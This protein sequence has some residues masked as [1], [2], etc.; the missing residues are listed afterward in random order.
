MLLPPIHLQCQGH[1]APIGVGSID[2][3][4]SFS[5]QYPATGLPSDFR[6]S[7]W[8]IS[9]FTRDNLASVWDSGKNHSPRSYAISVADLPL[10][11]RTSYRWHL[12]I[13]DQNDQELPPAEAGFETGLLTPADWQAQWVTGFKMMRKEFTLPMPPD[14]AR[15]YVSAIGYYEVAINGQRVGDHL[16]DPS[17]TDFRRR[18]EF[19]THDVTPLLSAGVNVLTL[20]LGGGFPA[21]VPM[22]E[23]APSGLVQLEVR[24]ADTQ[25]QTLATD[26]TWRGTN[27]GPIIE[28]SLYD[29]ETFDAR[30]EIPGWEL[31][32]YEGPSQPVQLREPPTGVLV[33]QTHPPIRLLETW[34]PAAVSEL[35]DGSLV[36]DA[37]RYLSG[38]LRLNCRGSRGHRIDLVYGE[39]LHPDGTVNRATNL[40]ARCADAY[41]LEGAGEETWEPRFTY[42]GFRYVQITGFP[43]PPHPGSFLCCRIGSDNPPTAQFT[44]SNPLFEKIFE[45]LAYTHRN[46]QFGTPADCSGRG[47]RRGWLFD[48]TLSLPFGARTS[49]TH[50]FYIKWLEDILAL[51]DWEKGEMIS[52]VAPPWGRGKHQNLAWQGA[53]VQVPALL[54]EIFDDR[55]ALQRAWPAIIRWLDQLW[56]QCQ[57]ALYLPHRRPGEEP[58]F[59]PYAGDW[60]SL[61]TPHHEQVTNGHWL[62]LCMRGVE[63]A[64]RLGDHSLA[65]RW[66]KRVAAIRTAYHQRFY[67]SPPPDYT[68]KLAGHCVGW[69]SAFSE[70]SQLGQAFPLLLD[71]PPPEIR[72]L[73]WDNLLQDITSA[74]GEPQWTTGLHTYYLV[75]LLAREGCHDLI[76]SLFNRT[77]FPGY[78]FMLACGATTIWERWKLS[79]GQ[80]MNSHCHSG[81]VAPGIWF[82]T[83][84]A[85]VSHQPA[86]EAGR[87]FI[88]RPWFDDRLKSLSWKE[89]T[90]WGVIRLQWHRHNGG[91]QI[92]TELPPNC[93]GILHLRLP[94][95]QLFSLGTEAW[96]DAA[97]RD[98][99]AGSEEWGLRFKK[100]H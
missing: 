54:D 65:K 77:D 93:T 89:E 84:L 79:V 39:L 59:I 95:K 37:G 2:Q 63:L 96:G 20:H 17:H 82:V 49:A 35:S 10:L 81:L 8:R 33:P 94:Q 87:H 16:L 12:Q 99:R 23:A 69:Y 67:A 73:I 100:G 19:V 21:I 76:Y 86:P 26:H 5:W 55:T 27:E 75:Q 31:A 83:G 30:R 91:I 46:N 13:W 40:D 4:L 29:G 48:G 51:F 24:H 58:Y 80:E 25:R 44:C 11:S 38:W 42:H 15:L 68:I 34:K 64:N 62:M 85:G 18:I 50:Q 72:P 6:Q 57:D 61:E 78:G 92:E 98:L 71:V 53:L 88:F 36:I 56:E 43:G 60:L 52:S 32:G 47:E 3:P 7:A 70:T 90:P 74:R 45:T 9:L 22:F 28:N 97:S 1:A 14:E 66:D 41:I